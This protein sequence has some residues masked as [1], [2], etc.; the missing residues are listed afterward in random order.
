MKQVTDEHSHADT[1]WDEP[2]IRS[3]EYA[4]YIR[5]TIFGMN[6]WN[7]ISEEAMEVVRGCL[8]I[9]PVEDEDDPNTRW[10]LKRVRGS[11]WFLTY[12]T[13]IDDI[14]SIR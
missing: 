2:T 10:G 4:A 11:R 13:C 14:A 8:G 1:P 6:P 5:G 7:R 3:P 12:V 9:N